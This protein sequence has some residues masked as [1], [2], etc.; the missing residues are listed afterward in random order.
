MGI[1]SLWAKNQALRY[2]CAVIVGYPEEVDV[3]DTWP[4]N[5]EYYNSA[6]VV[7]YEGETVGNYRKSHLYYTDQKW[8][9]E[10][11]GFFA[12]PILGLGGTALGICMDIK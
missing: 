7:N 12:Q 4:A 1:S 5:L 11:N 8:A 9:L 10:G 2:D 3:S 6:I